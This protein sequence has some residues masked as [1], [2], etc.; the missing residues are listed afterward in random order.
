MNE[1]LSFRKM[2]T[3]VFIQ[4]LFRIGAVLCVTMGIICVAAG[5]VATRGGGAMVLSGLLTVILGPILVRVW[6]ECVL[7]LFRIYDVLVQ[8]REKG[9]STSA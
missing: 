9:S 2:I 4:I 6:C 7:I 8:I 1:Y 5:A 3:P